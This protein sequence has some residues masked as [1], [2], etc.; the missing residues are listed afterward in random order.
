MD[1]LIK[2]G[3]IMFATGILALGII[4]FIHRDFIIGRPPAW[5]VN[6]TFNPELAYISAAVLMMAAIAILLGKKGGP[7]AL[8]IAALILLL[9]VSRHSPSFMN[10]WPNGYKTF[11][12]VGGA[13]IIA[14][15]FF[16]NDDHITQRLRVSQRWKNGLL[17]VGTVLV[18]VFLIACGFAHFKWA[19]GVQNMVP[20]YI[21]FHLF[22]TY[23]C[24]VCLFAGG[25]GILIPQTRSL[26]ALLSGIMILGWFIL[27]H[28]PAFLANPNN[29]SD[30]MGVCESFA[31]SGILFVLAGI[32]RVGK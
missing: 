6:F 12:L 5:P 32:A 17:V 1:K 20:G 11:A 8:L 14:V 10:D 3:R 2:P 23:F 26:A 25:A 24:G 21:P 18:A 9:S 19:Q 16:K 29:P 28:V 13:L 30:R 15:S 22:W 4:C 31:F 7:A 27:L